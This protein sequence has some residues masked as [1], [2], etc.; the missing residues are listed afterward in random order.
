MPLIRHRASIALAGALLL[1]APAA[2]ADDACTQSY[3]DGQ[4][5]LREARL[6][7]AT[8]ALLVCARDPCP[9]V[10]QPECAR[11]LAEAQARTP[12]LVLDLRDARGEPVAGASVT[13]D[14]APWPDALAGLARDVDPGEH[15]IAASAAG[16]R[17]AERRVVV[18]E[19]SKARLVSLV[20]AAPTPPTPA[21]APAPP[22]PS[23]RIPGASW[24]L[25]GVGMAALGVF[26]GF[27]IGGLAI[28]SDLATC[29]PLCDQ[30]RV[31]AVSR[32]WV[33]A[34]VALGVAVVALGLAAWTWAR[35]QPQPAHP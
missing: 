8:A 11:W 14:G 19:A 17:T 20:L 33:V 13:L 10:L 12:S 4:H 2:R 3:V 21:P 32:D 18:P 9:R 24:A 34:D 7:E 29:R 27:S 35:A 6:L 23:A 22:P 31:D 26:A 28:R 30:A 5:H 15:V 16:R 1:A 25:G